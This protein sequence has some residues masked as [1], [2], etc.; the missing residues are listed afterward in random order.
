MLTGLMTLAITIQAAGQWTHLGDVDS[1]ESQ[2]ESLL[3]GCGPARVRID[4]VNDFVLRVR[5][6]P[7]GLF[8]RDFSWAVLDA[9]PRQVFAD[10]NASEKAIT[11]RTAAFQIKV[12]RQPFGLELRDVEGNVVLENANNQSLAWHEKPTTVAEGR[13]P[14]L[15]GVSAWWTF[16]TR[17]AVYGLGEKTGRLNKSGQA[18]TMWNSDVPGYAADFDPLYKSIPFFVASRDN[19]F[20]GVF[21]DNPYRSFFDFGQTQRDVMSFGAESG[22]L[23]IY[24]IAGP[25]PKDV[26][27]RYTDLTG[28][29]PLPPKWAIGYHQCRYSYYP[30]SR[31]REVAATFRKKR[32]P[33]DV[34]YFDID[35]MDGF[36]CFTWNPKWFPNPGKL[37]DDLHADGFHTIAIIDPGIKNEPGYFVFD[38]GTEKDA[39]LKR[40]DGAPYVGRVWPGDSVFPDF[41]NP[42]VRDW[43]SG[44]FTKFL[45]ECKIDGIWNDMNEPAD[46][47]GPNHTVP[48]DTRFDNEGNPASHHACHN[49][50]GMQMHRATFEGI[51]RARP[52]ERAYTLTRA[53]YAGGQRFGAAWTGDNVSS[54]QHLRMSIPMALNLGVS[55]MPVVGPDIGGFVGGASPRLYARWIQ[56]GALFPYSRTHT[57]WPSP[58]QEPWSFGP[59]VESIARAS[60]ERRYQLLP[61]LYTLFEEASRTGVPIL[62]PLWMEFPGE[63]N[64]N[65]DYSFML[66]DAIYVAPI[67]Q[68]DPGES[69][70]WLPSGAWYDMN[71]GAIHASGQPIP[72]DTGLENLPIFARAGAVIPM[73]STVQHTGEAPQEPLILDIWIGNEGKATLYE[74]DGKTLDY[75]KEQFARTQFQCNL[76]DDMIVFGM[77]RKEGAFAPPS[78]SPLLRLHGL[79]RPIESV[80]V[81]SSAGKTESNV[82]QPPG[83]AAPKGV[84]EFAFDKESRAWLVRLAEDDGKLQGARIRLAK[85]ESQAVEPI[86]INFDEPSDVMFRSDLLRPVKR[87]GG[88]EFRMQNTGNVYAVLRRQDIPADALPVIRLRVKTEHTRKIGIR[89]ATEQNP[90]LSDERLITVDVEPGQGV[91]EYVIDAAQ[92]TGG[93]WSGRVYYLRLDF[94]DGATLGEMITLDHMTFEPR[95]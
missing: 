34:I 35:Y 41:T 37:M 29:I 64:W 17:T 1:F 90:R 58:D 51:R 62:R 68:P 73:Q 19:R 66:G 22:E 42:S 5:M 48:L 88:L 77:H 33:C 55:G 49:V 20:W 50:Y 85:V 95:P 45:S 14:A 65:A 72:I 30:E 16:D 39:W 57:A 2:K 91:G 82:A 40:A 84:A 70:I 27:K 15:R 38:Q 75:Q 69:Y 76:K 4:A 93:R 26:V 8:E 86:A 12:F 59:Q 92:V 43:W 63:W 31:V 89:F 25:G 10:V 53:T 11:A 87:D 71:T 23:D 3:V 18:W 52:G 24:V 47:V 83:Q 80:A 32:I 67:T 21:L 7:D 28:R 36:R 6:A 9:S 13:L 44:L 74:D 60:L 81:L 78:R 46:F 56:M 94:M 79:T 61:Y 54:W